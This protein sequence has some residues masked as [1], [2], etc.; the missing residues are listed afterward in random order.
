MSVSRITFVQS[1]AASLLVQ[2]AGGGCGGVALS[3][4][5]DDNDVFKAAV[6]VAST[7]AAKLQTSDLPLPLPP[8]AVAERLCAAVVPL[9]KDAFVAELAVALLHARASRVGITTL[10]EGGDVDALS[11][12]VA[13]KLAV[14][15]QR[16][17]YG[18]RE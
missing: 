1:F 17:G 6:T 10:A 7:M 11:I 9:A 18:L 2:R 8:G 4:M 5:L 14:E 3:A 16:R 15:L 12:R 13:Q